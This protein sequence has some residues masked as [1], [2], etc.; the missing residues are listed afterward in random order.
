MLELVQSGR[1]DPF[2]RFLMEGNTLLLEGPEEY[3]RAVNV[4][5]TALNQTEQGFVLDR[6]VDNMSARCF[7]R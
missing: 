3:R 1:R 5:E 6:R 7:I 2:V 4:L